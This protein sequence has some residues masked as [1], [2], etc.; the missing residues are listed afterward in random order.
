MKRY[1][2]EMNLVEVDETGKTVEVVESATTETVTDSRKSMSAT[3]EMLRDHLNDAMVDPWEG[4]VF[5]DR[6]VEQGSQPLAEG[7]DA[8]NESRKRVAAALL[9]IR[10]M[11]DVVEEENAE[12]LVNNNAG[13]ERVDEDVR[14]IDTALNHMGMGLGIMKRR[15]AKW[16]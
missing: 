14:Q 12:M 9:R 3:L 16:I 6:Y 15:A 1:A 8:M 7:E 10:E 5:T 2:I 13:D 4:E 11:L